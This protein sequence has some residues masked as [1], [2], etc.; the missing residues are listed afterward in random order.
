MVDF[1][2]VSI[3][4]V[5]SDRLDALFVLCGIVIGVKIS[6][7]EVCVAA[8]AVPEVSVVIPMV[9]L[10]L[11]P[12]FSALGAVPTSVVV[13]FPA[14]KGAIDKLVDDTD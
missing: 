7:K 1:E 6:V 10:K 3:D 8:P 5:L 14:L 9:G 2:L 13:E 11:G 12:G 4:E